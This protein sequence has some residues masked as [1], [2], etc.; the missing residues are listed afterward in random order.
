MTENRYSSCHCVVGGGKF[1]SDDKKIRRNFIFT[2]FLHLP[3]HN[4]RNIQPK[5]CS[6]HSVKFML[7]AENLN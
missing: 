2:S 1:V 3:P 5:L 6:H 4:I 7:D